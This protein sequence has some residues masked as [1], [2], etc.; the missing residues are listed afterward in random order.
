MTDATL[1]PSPLTWA[2]AD[3]WAEEPPA[4][5]EARRRASEMRATV[6]SRAVGSLLRTLVASSGARAV[7]EVGSGTGVTGGWILS[8]LAEDGTLTTVDADSELQTAAGD[9]FE[10]LGVSHTR[11]RTIAGP[12]PDVL[13]R[14]SDG[15][16]DVLVVGPDADTD[17]AAGHA[18]LE[19]ARRLLRIGGIVIV[20]PLFGD[21]GV[22]PG[23][24]DLAHHLRDDSDW[25]ASAVTVGDGVLVAVHR[26]PEADDAGRDME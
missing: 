11:V 9:T 15:A 13:S 19:Q 16:Y 12:P 3:D 20:T 17:G 1:P 7:V 6:P 26:G 4:V 25:V 18:L 23:R 10:R 21:E 14:L 8:G 2:Y 5:V 24:R 22:A